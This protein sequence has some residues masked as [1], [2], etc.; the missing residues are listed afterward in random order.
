MNILICGGEKTINIVNT[1]K[2]RFASG[3]VTIIKEDKIR[4]VEKILGRGDYFDRAIIMEP[5]W[6]DDGRIQDSTEISLELATLCK[7]L[8]QRCANNTLFFFVATNREMAQVVYDE[9]LEI[10]PSTTILV[11]EPPYSVLFFTDLIT[12]DT[13]AVYPSLQFNSEDSEVLGDNDDEKSWSVEKY[14]EESIGFGEDLEKIKEISI[15]PED[16]IDREDGADELE[17][18]ADELAEELDELEEVDEFEE[19]DELDNEQEDTDDPVEW[20]EDDIND[21]DKDLDWHD[22]RGE[23]VEDEIEE[24]SEQ[25]EEAII[26]RDDGDK[27]EETDKKML[28]NFLG[29]AGKAKVP[30][31]K[32]R[33]PRKERKEKSDNI[34]AVDREKSD[35]GIIDNVRNILEYYKNRG[36]SIIIT[37]AEGSGKSTIAY[38][39]AN[40]INKLGFSTLLVDF[41]T[42]GRSQAYINKDAYDSVNFYNRQKLS[43]MQALGSSTGVSK[44]ANIIKPGM[45]ILTNSLSEEIVDYADIAENY[46]MTRLDVSSRGNYNMTIYDMPFEIAT[47]YGSTILNS[48][49]NVVVVADKSTWGVVKLLLDMTNIEREEVQDEIFSRAKICFNKCRKGVPILGSSNYGSNK[50]ILIKMDE[51]VKELIGISVELRFEYM[52]VIKEMRFNNSY[53][54]YWFTGRAYSDDREGF[55]DYL[56]LLDSIFGIGKKGR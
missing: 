12:K 7:L 6:T 50:N 3:A 27:S 52:E 33:K 9:S 14:P 4:D 20:Q 13:K 42:K 54:N 28:N 56:N 55:I 36:G 49:D 31:E 51:L 44:Y 48:C 10:H 30:K 21:E 8:E 45:H 46:K 47:N 5:A 17:E 22:D 19:L 11:K 41:D 35:D 32:K 18:L 16:I 34:S 43:L 26:P 23:D 37:G 25:V 40:T 38:N 53:E 15:N 39:L 29:E 2:S 1:L 24:T